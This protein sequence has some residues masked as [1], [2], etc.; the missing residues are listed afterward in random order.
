[1]PCLDI[2]RSILADLHRVL[3]PDAWCLLQ[4]VDTLSIEPVN[5][6][7]FDVIRQ[8]PALLIQTTR[9]VGFRRLELRVEAWP[10]LEVLLLVAYK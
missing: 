6:V 4:T 8:T 3:H 7:G 5:L 9:D 10:G 1:M 2:V